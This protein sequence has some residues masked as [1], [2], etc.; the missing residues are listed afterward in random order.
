MTTRL[1]V[2]NDLHVAD[3]PP[4]GRKEGYR[5]QVLAKL[6]EIAQIAASSPQEEAVLPDIR[7]L[8]GGSQ[9][10]AEQLQVGRVEPVMTFLIGTGD[11]FHQKRPSFSSHYLVSQL[12]QIFWKI[13]GAGVE[14]Y[15]LPGNHDTGPG[16]VE[17]LGS[18]P[19]IV[20]DGGPIHVV[21]PDVTDAARGMATPDALLLW[22][23]YSYERDADPTY[24]QLNDIERGLAEGAPHTVMI[25]HGSIVPPGEVRPYPHVPL[26]TIN[27]DGIDMLLTG[28]IHED[29][30]VHLVDNTW[31]CNVG[32]VGRTQRTKA[33]YERE[34]SVLDIRLNAGIVPSIDRIPLKSALPPE[35]IFHDVVQDVDEGVPDEIVEFA[36]ALARGLNDETVPIEQLLEYLSLER[37]LK[38]KVMA[39]LE[40]AGL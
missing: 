14:T 2:F 33:N 8:S 31:F 12:Q 15:L 13:A 19:L 40:E 6:E 4:I 28:H 25:A 9:F 1:V 30:G 5:E 32:S 27:L 16:G 36:G 38:E 11:L 10:P 20:L 7:E 21:A 26:Q 17:G 29:L 24:Y 34:V 22:R 35:E 23:P 37:V 3:R 18:Q 39:Y